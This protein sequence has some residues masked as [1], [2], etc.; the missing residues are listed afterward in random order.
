L[1]HAALMDLVDDHAIAQAA[2][3]HRNHVPQGHRGLGLRQLL[4]L[5]LVDPLLLEGRFFVGCITQQST[6]NGANDT[7]DRR[8]GSRF[9]VVV[10]DQ[11]TGNRTRQTA[12]GR[13]AL[14]VSLGTG[15][16]RHTS[17]KSN[18]QIANQ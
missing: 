18:R 16:H 13:A 14:G 1:L 5:V 2:P 17:G 4:L 7:S 8:T 12:E 3:R 11:S 9:A 15:Q 10:A 6:A